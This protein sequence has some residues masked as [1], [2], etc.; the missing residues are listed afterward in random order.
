[1]TVE[2]VSKEAE[3]ITPRV[4]LDIMNGEELT[5]KSVTQEDNNED[6][7]E[8]RSPLKKTFWIK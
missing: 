7:A 8:E 3:G 2:K 5:E 6:E 1:M 4:L